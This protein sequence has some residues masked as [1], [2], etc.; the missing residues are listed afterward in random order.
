MRVAMIGFRGLPHTYGG[1]EEIVRNIAPMLVE[2]G[3]EVIVYCRSNLFKDRNPLYKGVRRIFLP[4]IE[5]KFLGQLIHA[6]LAN[7][8][9]LFRHTDVIYVYT[10]P[11]GV[12]T[13]LPY[14]FRKRIVVNTDGFDWTRAKWGWIARNYFRLSAWVV[15]HT[16]TE[17]LSD[18]EAMREYYLST[19]NRDSTYIAYGANIVT[20]EHPEI[21]EKYGLEPGD[22]YLI[23]SRLVPENNAELIIKAFEGMKTTKL[24]AIAGAANFDS[25]W[26]R[27]LH[28]TKDPRVRFLG[29]VS[30]PEHMKELNCNCYAYIHGHSAGGS[31]PA[32]LK[33]LGTGSAIAALD[34]SCNVEVLTGKDGKEYGLIFGADVDDLRKKMQWMEDNPEAVGKLRMESP[35]RIREAYTYEHIADEYHALFCRTAARK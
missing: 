29:Q 12:H 31:N 16:A 20:S 1:G 4:T 15:V 35:D 3:E 17:L 30:D 10:L 26:V 9:V 7:I 18:A 11:S 28:S 25:A 33:A 13:I 14:L 27:K 34:T 6:T 23:A 5:H 19:Y 32:L 24:L 21:L 2:R 22:Y 8:D